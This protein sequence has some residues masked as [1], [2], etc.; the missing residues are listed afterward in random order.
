[1]RLLQLVHLIST[2]LPHT[3]MRAECGIPIEFGNEDLR[4]VQ[5]RY[6]LMVD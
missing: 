3:H 5:A 4:N 2:T 1:M 6:H